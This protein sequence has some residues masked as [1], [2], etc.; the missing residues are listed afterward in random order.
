MEIEKSEN[1]T[2]S[3]TTATKT[4]QKFQAVDYLTLAFLELWSKTYP[5]FS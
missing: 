5:K 4:V 2:N 1:K 3:G